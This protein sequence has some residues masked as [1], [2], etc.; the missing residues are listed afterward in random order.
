[1]PTKERMIA[2]MLG[3]VDAELKQYAEMVSPRFSRSPSQWANEIEA[4]A[5]LHTLSTEGRHRLIELGSEDRP[6]N[7]LPRR[8]QSVPPSD[9]PRHSPGKAA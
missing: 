2:A 7:P 5:R 4:I 8:A 9:V 3:I 6:A 1:M